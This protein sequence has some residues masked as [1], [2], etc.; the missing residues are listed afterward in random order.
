MK[1]LIDL[2][3]HRQRKK[4]QD[5]IISKLKFLRLDTRSR[6]RNLPFKKAHVSLVSKERERCQ[7]LQNFLSHFSVC[8]KVLE[9]R[10]Q[11]PRRWATSSSNTVEWAHRWPLNAVVYRHALNRGAWPPFISKA[12]GGG[13][14]GERWASYRPTKRLIPVPI[15]GAL[16]PAHHAP[17]NI[18]DLTIVD[19][20]MQIDSR[21]LHTLP[22][23][24]GIP[25][26]PLIRTLSL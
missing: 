10:S 12:G 15:S 17:P 19:Y 25:I 26:A 20:W 21:V 22:L 11:V 3:I 24:I 14:Q 9:A 1:Q 6:R 13:G 23:R 8:N 18:S 16:A 4:F 5:S 7:S 2:K